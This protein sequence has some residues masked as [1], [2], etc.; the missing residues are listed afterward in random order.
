MQDEAGNSQR[1]GAWPGVAGRDPRM[2]EPSARRPAHGARRSHGAADGHR[3]T[4]SGDACAE[5]IARVVRAW[6]F[7]LYKLSR[8]QCQC[9]LYGLSSVS[10]AV[11]LV[12]T[13]YTLD[14]QYKPH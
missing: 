2:S 9:G 14:R 5:S 11:T 10:S 6:A 8:V 1:S 3:T 13:R 12:F 4:H 7:L